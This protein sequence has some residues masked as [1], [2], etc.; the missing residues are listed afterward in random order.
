MA[1]T[2]FIPTIWSARL[3]AHL[4][5]SHVA[6]NF[7]NRNYEGEI[8]AQGD[9]VKIN[10]IGDITIG[11]YVKNTNM[12]DPEVLSTVDQMLV[13]D[14]AKSFNFQ[15]DDVDKVQAKGALVDVAMQRAG[16]G[17]SDVSDKLIFKTI[18]LAVPA[19]NTIG[20]TATPIALTKD[21]AYENI[22][23]LKVILDKANVPT[24]GRKLAVP[25]EFHA[26]LLLDNRFVGTGGTEAEKA[27]GNGYVGKTAGFTIYVT[28]NLPNA[29]GKYDIIAAHDMATTYAEQI[30]ST[31]AYRMEKRFADGVKGLHVYG[32]KNTMP[33]AVAKIIGTFA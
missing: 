13:I 6:T 16:Y 19:G 4:D 32:A 24:E 12:A 21:N 28:N 9:R 27:L 11:D 22:V 25:P 20:V 17:L 10:S 30:V 23:K 18:G 29:T 14:Q 3:L 2:S 31:E 15:V 1:I 8:T 33:N 5:N 7:V 26:L